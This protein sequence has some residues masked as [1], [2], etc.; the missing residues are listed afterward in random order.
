LVGVSAIVE[1]GVGVDVVVEVGVTLGELLYSSVHDTGLDP[2]LYPP[3]ASPA[4]CVPA[5]PKINLATIKAPP[6]DH[7]EPFYSSVHDSATTLLPNPP[8]ASPAF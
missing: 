3:K 8:K 5:P 7:D 2:A 4:V 6:A 1:V